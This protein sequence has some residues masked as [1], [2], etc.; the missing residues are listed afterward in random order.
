MLDVG[1]T[2]LAQEDPDDVYAHL[3]GMPIMGA[4]PLTCQHAQSAHL[5]RRH[6]GE[7]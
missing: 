7:R 6:S 3:S 5:A 4:K 1:R 2:R